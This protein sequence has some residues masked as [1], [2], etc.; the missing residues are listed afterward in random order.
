[1]GG[2]AVL[3]DVVHALGA[4]LHLDV[5]AGLV[6]DRNVQALV[7][8]GLGVAHPV[9]KALGILLI[10]FC[11]KAEYLPAK[12]FFQGVVFSVA[13]YDEAHGENIK[14]ALERN[15][16]LDH[17]LPDGVGCLGADLHLIVDAGRIQFPLERADE[18]FHQPFAVLF[19]GFEL[20]GDEPILLG[21]GVFEIDVLHLPFHVVQAQLVGQRDV[22]HERFQ[23]LPLPAGLREHL[24]ASHHLQAVG[25]LEDGH[26]RIP[27]VLDDEFLVVLGLQARVL[28]LD[29][30]NLVKTVH[31]RADGRAPIGLLYLH[32]AHPAGLMQVHGGDAF[33][34]QADFIGHDG[35]DGIRVH[36]ERGSVVAGY[37]LEGSG[38]CGAG[39]LDEGR[40]GHVTGLLRVDGR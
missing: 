12:L 8:V 4:D 14:N 33:F 36:D 29:G 31:Q 35:G 40:C 2:K 19:S 17:L 24:E 7:A 20:V 27:G 22:Q 39:F 38:G 6:L 25:Q 3:R 9:P 11:H 18:L 10:F 16:L 28:G 34:R 23:N 13:V 26:A 32:A 15:F 30:G 21:L 37:V 5:G 1:M